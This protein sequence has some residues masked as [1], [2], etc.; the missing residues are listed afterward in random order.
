MYVMHIGLIMGGPARGKG[1][2]PNHVFFEWSA[3]GQG[4]N[5]GSF[6]CTESAYT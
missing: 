6:R 4:F 1:V 5:M 3:V 2:L